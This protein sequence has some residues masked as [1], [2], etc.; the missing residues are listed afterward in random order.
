[1][2]EIVQGE[3]PNLSIYVLRLDPLS[4]V[5]T[6]CCTL[7]NGIGKLNHHSFNLCRVMLKQFIGLMLIYFSIQII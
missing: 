5:F 7:V 1:M 2:I 6:C 3:I 4:N